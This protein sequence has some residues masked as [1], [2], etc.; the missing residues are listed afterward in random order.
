[1]EGEEN[2]DWGSDN[3]GEEIL[4]FIAGSVEADEGQDKDLAVHDDEI[5]IIGGVKAEGWSIP[6][7][8][9]GWAPQ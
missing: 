9:D 4:D 5:N 8:P 3:E 7:A 1:M 6:E 2:C